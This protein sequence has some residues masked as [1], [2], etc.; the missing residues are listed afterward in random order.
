M[1]YGYLAVCPRDL[2]AVEEGEP[3]E[4]AEHH[5]ADVVGG[6]AKQV[7][8]PASALQYVFNVTIGKSC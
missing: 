2:I 1:S 4:D 5:P 6:D 3:C 8:C 7:G